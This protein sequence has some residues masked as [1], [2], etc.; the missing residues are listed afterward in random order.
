M[1]ECPFFYALNLKEFVNF[2]RSMKIFSDI[3]LWWLLPIVAI[4]VTASVF[5]YKNQQQLADASKGQRKVLI[6]FRAVII[7]MLLLFLLGIIIENK[8]YKTEK[9]IF[10]TLVDNSSSMLN[11]K[12]SS[13]VKKK[14]NALTKGIKEKYKE[15]FDFKEYIVGSDVTDK[16]IDFSEG[17][18][19][20]DAGFEFIYSQFYNRNI[21]GI[22]FV[23]DGNYTTGK[24]PVYS[25]R[26]I[27]LT[28]VFSIGVGDTVVKRDQLVRVVSANQVAFFKNDFPIEIDIE[29]RKMGKGKSTVRLFK[30]EK[31]IAQQSVDYI[32]GKLDFAHVNFLVN[33]DE[34]GFVRYS[35]RIENKQN[36]I[37]YEN[38]VRT[39]YIEVIDSRTKVLILAKS[40]H[41]DLTSIHSVF[42]QDENTEAEIKLLSDWNGSLKDYA[43]LVWHNP[44]ADQAV[45][46]Q[47]N[48]HKIPVLYMLTSQSNGGDASALNIGMKLSSRNGID[49]VQA[50]LNT[51]FQLFELSDELK[52]SLQLWPPLK[53]PFG[54]IE[55]NAGNTL[56]SQR[57]GQVKKTDPILYFG[58]DMNRKY[59]V[60]IGEGLWRWKLMEFAK[61]QKTTSYTELI[62]RTTQYLTVKNNTD[63]FRVILPK[64]FNKNNEV[65]LKAEY[66]NASMERITTPTVK[67]ELKNEENKVIPYE[68]AKSTSDY[69]LSLGKLKQ[70]K[71]T[72][73]ASAVSNG[74]TTKKSGVFV[75]EDISIEILST[76]A[77]HGLLK[78]IA[79]E[80][81]GEFYTL[82]KSEQLLQDLD[83]RKDIVNIQYE[84]SNFNDLIDWKWLFVLVVILLGGEWFLRRYWGT[85]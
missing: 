81:N 85:Y 67:F 26:K 47:I 38:N 8:E 25:A 4:A 15:R 19:N 58:G 24:S 36:E 72:W 56:L 51:Q 39:F 1:R 37:T 22:C 45:I 77:N 54:K 68:F 73:S 70:G 61:T 29:A 11:Y 71:Y 64:R 21:G 83:I 40:P 44:G 80:T 17:E 79:N 30:G 5:Y 46:N 62:Q 53:V 42:E 20:L 13:D 28:P 65:L 7:A 59:G 75:V 34:I 78:Q 3:S 48:T 14:L 6:G 23:S 18:S 41:P 33:A 2:V 84:E 27:N 55:T 50:E 52:R 82:S 76:H 31:E 35:V 69:T 16:R 12:D 66:Y 43:L 60:I 63:P 32:D 10:I 49:E 9:P 74:K 57:I